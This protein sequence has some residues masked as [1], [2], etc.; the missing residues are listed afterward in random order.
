VP[1]AASQSLYAIGKS[2]GGGG[3]ALLSP[4]PAV[5]VMVAW[6]AAMLVGGAVVLTRRDA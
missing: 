3:L 4:G 1:V 2:D 5:L 6:I